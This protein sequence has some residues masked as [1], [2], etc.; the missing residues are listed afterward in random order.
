MSDNLAVT[1]GSGASVA[2]LETGGVHHQ[3]SLTEFVADNGS[4]KTVSRDAGLPVSAED[5]FYLLYSI[6]E[7]MP[8]VDTADRLLVSSAEAQP[9][10]NIAS[11]QTLAA[12]TTVSN[13]GSRDA[14][15][16]A[17]AMANVGALH[18]YNNIL[19]T[20]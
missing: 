11:A 12:V 1:P 17:Y 18:I 8:R 4:P 15:H 3:K 9:T 6:L 20:T 10:V 5:I 2:S 16:V 19:V 14:S 13:I 7:K